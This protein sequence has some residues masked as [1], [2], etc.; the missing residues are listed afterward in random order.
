MTSRYAKI[1]DTTIREAFD[2]YQAQQIDIC[3]EPVGYGPDAP[4]ASAE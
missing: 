4:T 1:H 3:G 2:R